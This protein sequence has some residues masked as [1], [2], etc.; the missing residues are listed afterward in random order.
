MGVVGRIRKQGDGVPEIEGPSK[1]WMVT[2]V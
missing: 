1:R 2:K